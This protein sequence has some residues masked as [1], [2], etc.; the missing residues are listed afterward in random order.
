MPSNLLSL[1]TRPEIFMYVNLSII[2]RRTKQRHIDR[3]ARDDL[4]AL[5]L[6]V[7]R[8]MIR[9]VL[10]SIHG[11]RIV[12]RSK[13]TY[14]V[15]LGTDR[16]SVH[17]GLTNNGRSS[18]SVNGLL[19]RKHKHS[20]GRSQCSSTRRNNRL[21]RRGKD[22]KVFVELYSMFERCRRSTA[23]SKF[24][25]ITIKNIRNGRSHGTRRVSRRREAHISTRKKHKPTHKGSYASNAVTNKIRIRVVL[26][27]SCISTF[28]IYSFAFNLTILY[29][30]LSRHILYSGYAVVATAF[31]PCKGIIVP[32]VVLHCGIRST[33]T[34]N[35]SVTLRRNRCRNLRSITYCTCGRS[36]GIRTTRLIGNLNVIL[37]RRT[38]FKRK[39][40][41]R[42]FLID[43]HIGIKAMTTRSGIIT[44]LERLAV[45]YKIFQS[46]RD[47]FRYGD[48]R[49]TRSISLRSLIINVNLTSITSSFICN[50][51]LIFLQECAS[52]DGNKSRLTRIALGTSY[53]SRLLFFI[54]NPTETT[55]VRNIDALCIGSLKI[56]VLIRQLLYPLRIID[57]KRTRSGIDY[58]V[59]RGITD[60]QV[61]RINL[62][63]SIRLGAL[64]GLSLQSRS[65]SQSRNRIR[66]H[67]VLFGKLT[68]GSF[69]R[70]L[71]RYTVEQRRVLHFNDCHITLSMPTCTS[72]N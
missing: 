72:H 69:S 8:D 33:N 68:I 54:Q 18:R 16:S 43:R 59:N 21:M 19:R 1:G 39:K 37:R 5:P 56:V 46:S 44:V 58:N 15:V 47:T 9:Q 63:G 4:T 45:L 6:E 55:V 60:L 71:L 50:S 11:V 52:L 66:H 13:F 64:R 17:Q 2:Y 22:N 36:T 7:L 30:K 20:I 38:A 24:Y 12:R 48:S 26:I 62:I 41:R 25:R 23:R 42:A 61:L 32:R 14:T 70:S 28:E 10:R 65:S 35:P 51:K 29:G 31:I 40:K 67:V 34:E 57:M 49:I 53:G 3:T 27:V